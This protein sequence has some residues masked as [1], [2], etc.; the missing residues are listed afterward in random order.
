[1]SISSASDSM[2]SSAE[3]TGEPEILD[4]ELILPDGQPTIITVQ[5][6]WVAPPF[7]S[8]NVM[9]Y[10]SSP[11]HALHA[12]LFTENCALHLQ[13]TDDGSAYTDCSN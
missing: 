4:M 9:H 5:S 12:T 11:S 6:K 7:P 8:T 2:A 1:M 10:L 3:G 13:Q